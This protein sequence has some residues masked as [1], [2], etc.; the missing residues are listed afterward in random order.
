MQKEIDEVLG[1]RIP[2][3]EDMR[4]LEQ[5]RL[6]VTE[7]LRLFPEPPLLIRR[8]LEADTLPRGH[9]VPGLSLP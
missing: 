5:C 6:V 8:A 9:G 2:T 4:S 1:D 7:T 3:Y